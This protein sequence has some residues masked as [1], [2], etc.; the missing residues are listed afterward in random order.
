MPDASSARPSDDATMPT[1]A[2]FP[3][4]ADGLAITTYQWHDVTGGPVGIVQLVHG[5]AEHGPRYDRFARALNAAGFVVSAADNRGHGASVFKDV[6][7]GS[8]GAAGVEGFVADIG[9]HARCWPPSIRTCRSSPSP[10]RSARWAC[11]SRCW[12]SRSATAAWCSAARRPSTASAASLPTCPPTSRGW[13]RSTPASSR[14]SRGHADQAD[15]PGTGRLVER[16]ADDA[17][18]RPATKV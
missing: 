3:S 17:A 6:P 18:Q 5:L 2:S 9:A 11:R 8:F 1:T 4:P 12:P 13:P 15:R 16:R 10:T 7:R 14:S